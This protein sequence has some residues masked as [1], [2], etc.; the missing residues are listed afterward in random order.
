MTIT[1]SYELEK[2]SQNTFNN[3]LVMSSALARSYLNLVLTTV[4]KPRCAL[5]D[6]HHRL[7]DRLCSACKISIASAEREGF[8]GGLSG[9]TVARSQRSGFANRTLSRHTEQQHQSKDLGALDRVVSAFNY[10]GAVPDLI[11]R[12]KYQ[13]MIELTDYIAELVA[14]LTA[15][16]KLSMP[17][18]NLVTVIPSHWQR[19][20]TRGF[21]PVWLLANALTKKGV[22]ERPQSTLKASRRMPY[23][24]LKRLNERHISSDHFQATESVFGKKI[25]LLDDVVTSGSTL[26]AAAAALRS[27]GA[28]SVNGFTV[29]LARTTSIALDEIA[30]K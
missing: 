19:R 13:G 14:E 26:N 16:G 23:Q 21:D 3:Y 20:L 28:K 17:D 18:H 12:W 25:L 7:P 9:S 2:V 24:H 30:E 1:Q 29:A 27:A 11:T 5:C 22:V 6:E 4:L 15:K 10:K 8:A